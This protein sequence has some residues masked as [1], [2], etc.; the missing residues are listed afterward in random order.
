MKK[1]LLILM[2][3][4]LSCLLFACGGQDGNEKTQNVS[5]EVSS[6]ATSEVDD[7]SIKLTADNYEKY[8][9]V[10][11]T[12]YAT[13]KY[14]CV[15][16][17]GKAGAIRW[18]DEIYA[19][20]TLEG[21]SQNFNYNDIKIVYKV[22]GQ[23]ER[24]SKHPSDLIKSLDLSRGQLQLTDHT[25]VTEDFEFEFELETDIVGKGTGNY[26]YKIPGGYRTDGS[27]LKRYTFEVVSISGTVTPA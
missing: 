13:G 7:G 22:V 18:C 19:Y 11:K 20:A 5:S 1:G 10:S 21:K 4:S 24:F 23:Y 15:D 8:I 9:N 14:E 12:C 27:D 25:M 6:E 2:A 16:S 3:L 26:T 17:K